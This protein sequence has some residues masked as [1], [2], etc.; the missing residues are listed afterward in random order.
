MGIIYSER[1]LGDPIENIETAIAYYEAALQVWNPNFCPTAVPSVQHDLEAA[2][3]HR[4]DLYQSGKKINVFS[5]V[6]IPNDP[7]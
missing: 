2:Y 3:Q 6:D 4:D 5:A 7:R 1:L